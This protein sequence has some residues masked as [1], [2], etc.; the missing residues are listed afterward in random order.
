TLVGYV[1]AKSGAAPDLKPLTPLIMDIASPCLVFVALARLEVPIQ[2]LGVAALAALIFL[3]VMGAAAWVILKK[4][5]LSF[6]TYGPS[7]TFPNN[8]NLGL[9]ISL[10]AFGQIGFSYALAFFV[11][12]NI[13]SQTVGRAIASGQKGFGGDIWRAPIL[14]ASILGVLCSWF[15]I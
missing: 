5:N 15:Q 1:W 14:P 12:M 9:P 2:E 11:V 8:G 10:M 6:R 13:T 4:L 3:A 7:L